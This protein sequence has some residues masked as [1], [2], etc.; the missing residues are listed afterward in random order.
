MGNQPPLPTSD[1]QS[2]WYRSDID[3]RRSEW[4]D[5]RSAAARG[6]SAGA[7]TSSGGAEGEEWD[8]DDASSD[9]LCVVP[10][11]VRLCVSLTPCAATTRR[12]SST[13]WSRCPRSWC[14]LPS[15]TALTDVDN[16]CRRS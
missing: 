16:A 4:K 14:V 15:C 1:G 12:M 10:L 3:V 9:I 8:D 7:S 13:R 5:Y 11:C 2:D 6:Q